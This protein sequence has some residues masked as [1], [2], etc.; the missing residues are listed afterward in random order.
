MNKKGISV[1]IG[2]VLLIT[3]GIIISVLVYTYLKTFVPSDTPA[4]PDGVSLYLKDYSYNCSSGELNLTLKNNGK[5]KINGYFAHGTTNQ[6]VTLATLDLSNNFNP[7][8]SGDGVVL[9]GVMYFHTNT[10]T[11]LNFGEE[12]FQSFD[13]TNR[14]YTLE[15][16]P[17]RFQTENNVEKFTSCGDAKIT[18]ALE[19]N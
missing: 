13:L 19:C 18:Q 11:P 12:S 4:C 9:S 17:I 8:I 5:F 10:S 14:T 7:V 6:N 1:V 3:F 2:Y 15:I 16:I